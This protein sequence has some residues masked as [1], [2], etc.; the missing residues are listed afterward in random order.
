MLERL[1]EVPGVWLDL[2]AYSD[3]YDEMYE[4]IAFCTGSGGS[5]F[6]FI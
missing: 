6:I 4:N 3:A 2:D 5:G 1:G